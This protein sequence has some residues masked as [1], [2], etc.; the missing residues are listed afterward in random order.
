MKRF[1]RQAL[2]YCVNQVNIKLAD[3]GLT[4]CFRVYSENGRYK[5]MEV[6]LYDEWVDYDS[7]CLYTPRVAAA[8]FLD[9][10][11]SDGYTECAT[12]V[13]RWLS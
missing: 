4:K 9:R 10:L 6:N 2:N 1:T 13:R 11:S 8:L 3:M 12:I 7:Y 5:V